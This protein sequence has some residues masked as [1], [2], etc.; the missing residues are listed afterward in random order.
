MAQAD[1]VIE[2]QPEA[3]VTNDETSQVDEAN[4]GVADEAE[5]LETGQTPE[6]GEESRPQGIVVTIGDAPA[7]EDDP[8]LNNP[9]FKEL[10]AAYRKKTEEAREYKRKLEAVAGVNQP[11]ELG[12]MPTL[13]ECDYDTEKFAGKMKDWTAKQVKAEAV[14]KSQLEANARAAAAWQA[15]L[16]GYTVEKEKFKARAPDF[17]EAEESVR[18]SLNVMQQGVIIKSAKDVPLLFYALHKNPAKLK[19]LAAITD[20]VEFTWNMAQLEAQLKVSNRGERPQ[21]EERVGGVVATG[22]GGDQA[23]EKLRAEAAKTGD[24]TKV[25]AHKRKMRENNKAVA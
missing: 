13:E 12:P 7:P 19:E 22:R 20:P 23:L 2:G 6:A 5:T 24:Y 11:D 16:N 1:G 9:S 8:A 18:E 3:G 21:A 17:D 14:K 25:Y 10:R 15:K 4:T